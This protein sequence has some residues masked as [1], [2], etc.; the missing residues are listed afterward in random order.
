M[1]TETA[2]EIK[3]SETSGIWAAVG[4]IKRISASSDPKAVNPI[5]G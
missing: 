1:T 2:M 5:G 3:Q 4:N